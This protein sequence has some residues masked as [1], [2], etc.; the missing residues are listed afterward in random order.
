MKNIGIVLLSTLLLLP[1][2]RVL[3]QAYDAAGPRELYHAEVCNEGR[4]TVEVAVAY[5]DFGFSDEFWMIDYWYRAEPGKCKLVFSHFYAPNNLFSFQ[6]FPLYLAFA[7]TD[8]TGVW[9]AAKVNP[10]RDTAASRLHLCVGRKNYEYRVNGKN[11][12]AKCPQAKIPQ[13]LPIPAAMVW[14]PTRGVYARE[15]G[16]YPPPKRFTVALGQNDRAIA[17]GPQASPTPAL[18]GPDTSEAFR[19]LLSSAMNALPVSEVAEAQ[20]RLKPGYRHVF[21]CVARS[22]VAKESWSNLQ[23][24]RAKTLTN[25]TKKFLESHGRGTVRFR[26]TE[27]NGALAVEQIGGKTGDCVDRRDVDR[28]E[29][30]FIFQS[31]EAGAV[32]GAAPAPPPAAKP[33]PEPAPGFGDLIGPGGFI[34]PPPK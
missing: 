3:A 2:A 32:I 27:L 25:A 9:G 12:E 16:G 11:P 1:A 7:F 5:K 30:E 26:V 18:Q 19:K 13:S 4:I 15:F 14:E 33:T 24:A 29:Y 10:A 17:L 20:Y 21:T 6:S 34:K 22:V 31:P 23:T 8:S 28:G